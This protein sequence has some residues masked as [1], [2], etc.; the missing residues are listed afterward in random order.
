VKFIPVIDLLDGKVVH[1]V[2]DES[3]KYRSVES[4][5]M[6]QPLILVQLLP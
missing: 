1:A 3:E 4:L 6:P 2:S 5:L